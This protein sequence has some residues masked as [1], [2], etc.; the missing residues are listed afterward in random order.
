MWTSIINVVIGGGLTILGSVCTQYY[1]F[2]K[3]KITK[4]RD[5]QIKRMKFYAKL[6]NVMNDKCY[7]SNDEGIVYI[8]PSKFNEIITPMIYENIELLNKDL[9]SEFL[10]Y[11]EQY[12]EALIDEAECVAVGYLNLVNDG[13]FSPKIHK[14]KDNLKNE[15]LTI[16]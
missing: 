8:S 9:R 11:D 15:I 3:D 7:T 10:Y 5:L 2:K 12:Q 4:H 16:K 6:L 14:F 1:I 13:D